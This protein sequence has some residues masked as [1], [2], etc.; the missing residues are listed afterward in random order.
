M[1][2]RNNPETDW[3]LKDS[4]G[5]TGSD[6]DIPVCTGD[7]DRWRWEQPPSV[8]GVTGPNDI[9]IS[10]R[11]FRESLNDGHAQFLTIMCAVFIGEVLASM[12]HALAAFVWGLL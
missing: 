6:G 8:S 10:A 3:S 12:A 11:K 2:E 9:A 4:A 1:T 5:N 7:G